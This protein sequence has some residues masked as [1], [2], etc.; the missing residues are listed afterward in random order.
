MV[1]PIPE[2]NPYNAWAT[3]TTVKGAKGGLLADKTLVLK[4][5]LAHGFTHEVRAHAGV[6]DN[7]CLAGVP[8]EFGT[9]V[10]SDWV[11]NTDATVV[12]RCLEAG[13]IVSSLH[14]GRLSAY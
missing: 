6:Q 13:A 9:K 4:A 3:K 12:K 10:F 14:S 7:I 5:S 2:Y 1:R 8:C 11:P